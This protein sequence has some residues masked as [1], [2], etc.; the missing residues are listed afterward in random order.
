MLNHDVQF[1]GP[2]TQS[3]G[4]RIKQIHNGYVLELYLWELKLYTN[5]QNTH[6]H[7]Y[8]N[9]ILEIKHKANLGNIYRT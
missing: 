9:M 4:P 3:I 5:I 6:T 1:L 7:P 8:K 2:G